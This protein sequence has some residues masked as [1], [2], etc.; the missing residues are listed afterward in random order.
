MW[1]AHAACI[2]VASV[3]YA[4]IV[5]ALVREVDSWTNCMATSEM[6]TYI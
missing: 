6:G 4:W 2:T 5:L 1:L 3:A